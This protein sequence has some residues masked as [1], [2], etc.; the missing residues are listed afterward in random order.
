MTKDEIQ[1]ITV[2]QHLESSGDD[3]M[4]AGSRGAIS[5]ERQF[6][7]AD[8]QMELELLDLKYFQIKGKVSLH[9]EKLQNIDPI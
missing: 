6:L 1:Q 2:F 7:L 8:L 9:T 5:H 3:V 4:L